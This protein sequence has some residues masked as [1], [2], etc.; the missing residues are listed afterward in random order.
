MN[1]H[2][3]LVYGYNLVHIASTE[4]GFHTRNKFYDI[5]Y[6]NDIIINTSYCNYN[7]RL[8]SLTLN[9]IF[10]F[11][12]YA[13]IKSQYRK[14]DYELGMY[15]ETELE[16]YKE[17]VRK[18]EAVWRRKQALK[19][20]KFDLHFELFDYPKPLFSKPTLVV[21]PIFNLKIP[22]PISP[23]KKEGLLDMDYTIK[24]K[25][26]VYTKEERRNIFKNH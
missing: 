15:E 10:D 11:T 8:S 20:S 9:E 1:Y 6:L 21:K 3:N 4:Q 5:F 25:H 12:E 18:H 14:Y 22:V 24:I 19:F 26:Q 23:Y 17:E 16:L 2:N 7:V 13:S